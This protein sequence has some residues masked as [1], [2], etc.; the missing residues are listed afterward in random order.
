MFRKSSSRVLFCEYLTALGVDIWPAVQRVAQ[1]YGD[2]R[3]DLLVVEPGFELRD[4]D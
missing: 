2:D 3:I 1:I 4:L